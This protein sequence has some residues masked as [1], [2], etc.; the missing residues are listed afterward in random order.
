MQIRGEVLM[1]G[2]KKQTLKVFQDMLTR[3]KNTN[4]K[5]KPIKM[6]DLTFQNNSINEKQICYGMFYNTNLEIKSTF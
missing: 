3:K 5:V 2:A 6:Q 1:Q 4:A